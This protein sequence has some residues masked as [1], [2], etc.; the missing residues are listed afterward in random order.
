MVLSRPPKNSDDELGQYWLCP[1]FMAFVQIRKEK[2]RASKDFVQHP[3]TAETID[4]PWPFD[5]L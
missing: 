1:S 5:H 4:L 3:T 2:H